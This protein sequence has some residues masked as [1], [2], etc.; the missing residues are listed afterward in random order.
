MAVVPSGRYTSSGKPIYKAAP[1]L[2]D[3][4]RE[5]SQQRVQTFTSGGT[6]I[7]D[8]SRV[9]VSSGGETKWV[10]PES[11]KSILSEGSIKY[12]EAQAKIESRQKLEGT[13]K[14]RL[15]AEELKQ[16]SKEG[17]AELRRLFFI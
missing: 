7:A 8:T 12:R 16:M 5:A 6:K 3:V 9:E 11:A 14:A 10:T 2:T 4:K 13:I 17:R 1:T 15:E